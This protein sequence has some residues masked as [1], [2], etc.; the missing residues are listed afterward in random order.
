L[1]FYCGLGLVEVRRMENEK[2]D[3]RCFSGHAG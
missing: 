3:L 1:D 2:A